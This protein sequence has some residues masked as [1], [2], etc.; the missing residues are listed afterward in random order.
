MSFFQ[1]ILLFI[2]FIVIM[3][4]IME[5]L[6]SSGNDAIALPLFVIIFVAGWFVLLGMGAK[7]K[8]QSIADGAKEGFEFMKEW[9]KTMGIVFLVC[10]ILIII[11]EAMR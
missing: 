11:F 10:L 9:G 4:F 3:R 6:M 7:D 2:G 1:F 8:N 5:G